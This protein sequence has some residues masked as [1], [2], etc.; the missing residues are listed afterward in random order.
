MIQNITASLIILLQIPGF[1]YAENFCSTFRLLEA[2]TKKPVKLVQSLF[3]L[4]IESRPWKTS[5]FNIYL[6]RERF[7]VPMSKRRKILL[8]YLLVGF[9][10]CCCSWIS[11]IFLLGT[12]DVQPVIREKKNLAIEFGIPNYEHQKEDVSFS[13]Q[14]ANQ[15]ASFVDGKITIHDTLCIQPYYRTKGKG[16]SRSLPSNTESY[17]FVKCGEKVNLLLQNIKNKT[18]SEEAS[19]VAENFP[20]LAIDNIVVITLDALSRARYSYVLLTLNDLGS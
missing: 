12:E 6:S 8:L 5:L 20:D 1:I 16:W 2:Q 19:A 11:M 9:G 14:D 10:L 7:L 17:V 3:V 4:K 15:F 18:L 13:I